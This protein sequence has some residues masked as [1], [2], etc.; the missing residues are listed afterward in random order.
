VY[1]DVYEIPANVSCPEFSAAMNLESSRCCHVAA[2]QRCAQTVLQCGDVVPV[3]EVR[4]L[5]RPGDEQDG[6]AGRE[7]A[8]ACEVRLRARRGRDG[9]DQEQ[10]SDGD[11]ASHGPPRPRAERGRNASCHGATRFTQP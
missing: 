5:A 8:G 1:T 6:R 10:S 9:G 11:Q 7:I 4:V 2:V 3:E